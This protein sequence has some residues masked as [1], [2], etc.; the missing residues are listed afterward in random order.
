VARRPL[1]LIPVNATAQLARGRELARTAA[2]NATDVLHP[3]ITVSRGLRRLAAAGRRR[4]AGTPKDRRGPLLFL[5]G[6]VILAVVLVPYG[7][8]LAVVTLMAAAAR[9]GRDGSASRSAGPT[10]AQAARLTSLYEALVP[11]FSIPEDPAPL[12]AHGGDWSK[13]FPVYEF[14]DT[15]RVRHLVVRYPAYFADGEPEARARV[16]H[17]LYTKS[18][19]GREYRFGWDEEANDLN[20]TVL[21]PLPTDITAQPFVTAPGETVLGFTDAAS[22]QRTLPLTADDAGARDV[23]PVIWRTG[24]RSGEPHLLVLGEPGSGAT[25]L[26]RSIALQVLRHGDVL[27][28]DGT[29]SGEYAFLA[30]RDGVVAIESDGAGAVAS[31]EW[32]AHETERRLIAANHAR[33]YGE[34]VPAEVC[35]PLFVLL[36]RPTALAAVARKDP[37]GLLDVP[38]RYGRAAQVTVV[39]ADHF[40]ALPSLAGTVVAHTRARVALGAGTAAEFRAALGAPPPTTPL[41][42]VPPGRG[43]ARLGTRVH[44]LQVPATPNPYDDAAPEVQRAAVVSLLPGAVVEVGVEALRVEG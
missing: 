32:A 9:Q 37:Q 33:Q 29:G 38:L 24:P 31:L 17:L 35:R 23:P 16:E 5:V 34:A 26:L 12:F 20:V 41:P 36:D 27:I 7:P 15:G 8:A 39:V 1:P 30:G 11:Y 4:W 13:P 10:E 22:V 42:E 19:R 2:D 44:R 28:A 25:T 6:S 21:D 40:D 18:G 3:L 43:Y 14:D